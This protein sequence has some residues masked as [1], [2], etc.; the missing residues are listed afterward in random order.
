MY[1][2]WAPHL[3]YQQPGRVVAHTAQHAHYRLDEPTVVHGLGQ[4]YVAKIPRTIPE[5][6]PIRC[7]HGTVLVHRAHAQVRE[8]PSL[9]QA[10]FIG[11]ACFD[12]GD[13]ELALQ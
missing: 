13:R 6:R 4:L 11:I 7:A 8:T 12:L 5:V 1:G 2:A 9:R 3:V 10:L